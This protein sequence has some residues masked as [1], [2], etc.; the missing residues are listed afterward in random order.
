MQWLWII[1]VLLVVL[2]AVFIPLLVGKFRQPDSGE[3]GEQYVASVLKDCM[4]E[5]DKLINDV[6]VVNPENGNSSQI[7]H[8]LFSTRGIFVIE[9]KNLSGDIYGDD[10]SKEWKQVL[11]DGSIVHFHLS[12]VR[13]NNT[14]IYVLSKILKT[15][16]WLENIVVFVQDNT[17]YI[18]S[19]FVYTPQEL[20]TYLNGITE[21]PVSQ[22]ERDR[23]YNIV[24][25]Y[26]KNPPVTAS[27][28]RRN[29]KQNHR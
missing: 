5:G 4:R 16:V 12:P 23:L 10:L 15:R 1:P 19:E 7:D 13:Q 24:L 20:Y 3:D 14:H 27:Q 28:H 18:R 25:Q 11:G 22:R 29:I 21:R 17:H 6:I 8:I 9:T 2:L 26:K